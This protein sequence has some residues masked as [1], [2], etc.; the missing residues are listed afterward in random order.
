MLAISVP[1]VND[2]ALNYIFVIDKTMFNIFDDSIFE[3]FSI[4]IV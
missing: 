1:R 4:P 3:V 2:S